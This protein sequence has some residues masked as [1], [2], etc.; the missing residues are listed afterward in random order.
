MGKINYM[1]NFLVF[2][3][4]K[5][6]LHEAVAAQEEPNV[7][8]LMKRK[9]NIV[10]FKEKQEENAYKKEKIVLTAR[11]ITEYTLDT[12]YLVQKQS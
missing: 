6:D 9:A 12:E 8:F 1:E 4:H 7:Q 5:Y 11:E 10:N 2:T 3:S